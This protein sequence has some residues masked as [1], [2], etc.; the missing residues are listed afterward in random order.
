MAQLL[1][2][3][4]NLVVAETVLHLVDLFIR[5]DKNSGKKFVVALVEFGKSQLFGGE[6][7]A[8]KKDI[9]VC[10]CDVDLK[11]FFTTLK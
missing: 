5:A 7:Y 8:M 10:W 3:N 1:E 6:S 9:G 11:L 4:P 2:S